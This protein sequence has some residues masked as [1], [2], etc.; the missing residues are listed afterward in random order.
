MS[1][2]YSY[3]VGT[4]A[5]LVHHERFPEPLPVKIVRDDGGALMVQPVHDNLRRC[6]AHHTELRPWHTVCEDC[7]QELTDDEGVMVHPEPNGTKL[8]D[9]AL[10]EELRAERDRLLAAVKDAQAIL[11]AVRALIQVYGW[12]LV[13]DEAVVESCAILDAAL[14]PKEEK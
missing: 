14:A 1:D 12:D 5:W 13:S 6:L 10:I 4:L 11:Q 3:P 7:R 8:C 2:T 9:G